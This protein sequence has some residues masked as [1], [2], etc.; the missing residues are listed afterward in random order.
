MKLVIVILCLCGFGFATLPQDPPLGTD[1]SEGL[2]IKAKLDYEKKARAP[3][4]QPSQTQNQVQQKAQKPSV[5]ETAK[6]QPAPIAHEQTSADTPKADSTKLLSCKNGAELR[7]LSLEYRGHGCELSYIKA[8]QSKSQARQINGT[9]I[10]ESVFEKMK[11]TLEKTGFSC[12][13][14]KD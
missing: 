8:G 6:A 13:S 14:K 11:S 1:R 10:C 3:M 12:E 4:Q 2:Q 9:T 5:I 7:D